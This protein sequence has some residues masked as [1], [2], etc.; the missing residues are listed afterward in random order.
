MGKSLEYPQVTLFLGI[1][2]LKSVFN[3]K[4]FSFFEFYPFVVCF[5][6]SSNS[7]DSNPSSS[8]R[9]T[10]CVPRRHPHHTALPATRPAPH[11]ARCACA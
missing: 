7:A 11:P 8:H 9:D 3:E 10:P 4:E 1:A 5:V 2:F 6:L